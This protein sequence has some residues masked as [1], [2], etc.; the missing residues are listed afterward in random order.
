MNAS[1]LFRLIGGFNVNELLLWIYREKGED[2]VRR[3]LTPPEA[4][5][6]KVCKQTGA[7]PDAALRERNEAVEETIEFLRSLVDKD[8][9]DPD[10][11]E[12]L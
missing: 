10:P 9:E 5:V 8:F 6:R 4:W 2:A 1:F 12:V 3:F 7:D 11:A